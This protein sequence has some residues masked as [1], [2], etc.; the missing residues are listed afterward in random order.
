[1]DVA[2]DRD[3]GV[4]LGELCAGIS[5][6]L[7]V[8]RW[9]LPSMAR[10]A[11]VKE[12][13]APPHSTSVSIAINYETSHTL[14]QCPLPSL[15]LAQWRLTPWSKRPLT[16]VGSMCSAS[17]ISITLGATTSFANLRTASRSISSS[18]EMEKREA[19][20]GRSVSVAKDL[21]DGER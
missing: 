9:C 2:K 11:E 6:I 8:G 19:M 15:L 21:H 12:A 17:S 16:M 7:E 4:N 1:M 3:G 13:P 14:H 20:T 18:S 5:W 10:M